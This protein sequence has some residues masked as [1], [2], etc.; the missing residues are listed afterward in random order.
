MA[1]IEVELGEAIVEGA[2]QAGFVVDR[3]TVADLPGAESLDLLPAAGQYSRRAR[4]R[5]SLG[6]LA[7]VVGLVWGL[8]IGTWTMRVGLEVY[9]TRSELIRLDGARRALLGGQAVRHR[10]EALLTTLDAANTARH[11]LQDQLLAVAS[12][13]P[14]S[15]Y[16]SSV[17]ID[18][19]GRGLMTGGAHRATE[20]V[21][22]LERAHAAPNP[23]L[24]GAVTP[25]P[26][27]RSRWERFTIL[28]DG[29]PR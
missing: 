23:R 17:S 18:T 1:A 6:R 3:C 7:L 29:G 9:R 20:V 25:D 26:M 5:Q 16:L 12:A 21:A 27:S 15:A 24:E 2:A 14:D 11:R 22:A 28:L 13:L 10:A 4:R 19:L 8:A